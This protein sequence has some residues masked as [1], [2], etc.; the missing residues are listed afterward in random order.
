MCKCMMSTHVCTMCT[1]DVL[2]V[3]MVHIS[4]ILV[5]I[6]VHACMMHVSKVIDP[7]TCVYHAGMYDE[8]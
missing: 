3:C 5:L 8:F 6:L 1:Y 2:M 7:D 4:M